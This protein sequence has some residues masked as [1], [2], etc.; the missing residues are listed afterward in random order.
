MFTL[1]SIEDGDFIICKRDKNSVQR[2]RVKVSCFDY[3]CARAGTF[4]LKIEST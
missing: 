1:C 4:S 2:V 3:T